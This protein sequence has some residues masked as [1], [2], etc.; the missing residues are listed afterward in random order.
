MATQKEELE[1]AQEGEHAVQATP[2]TTSPTIIS[3]ATAIIS[4]VV[5]VDNSTIAPAD[6]VVNSTVENTEIV[7]DE[8]E[9][10]VSKAFADGDYGLDEIEEQ[11]NYIQPSEQGVI[12]L[13]TKMEFNEEKSYLALEF[14]QKVGHET[15]TANIMVFDPLNTGNAKNPE[16]ARKDNIARVLHVLG[17][18]CPP[19]KYEAMKKIKFNNFKQLQ[20]RM[21]THI[22]D[23]TKVPL[24]IMVGYTNGSMLGFPQYG[25]CISSNYKPYALTFNTNYLS[26]TPLVKAKKAKGEG[27][28]LDGGGSEETVEYLEM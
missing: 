4:D 26:L 18:M 20:E 2:A 12:A 3:P 24:K 27:M 23:Y 6:T 11:R 14:S 21:I 5:V 19:D 16:K 1:K 17:A 8:T 10:D 9:N 7:S 28:S 22:G 25:A 15:R 13:C